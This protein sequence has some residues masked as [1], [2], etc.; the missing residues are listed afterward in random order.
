LGLSIIIPAFEEGYSLTR[1]ISAICKTCEN[2]EFEIIIVV[3]SEIDSSI[4]VVNELGSTSNSIQVLVQAGRGPLNAIKF[5]ISNSQHDYLVVVTADDTDDATDILKMNELFNSG[6]HYVCASRYI[7]GG[8]YS[9]GPKVKRLFSRTASA[10]LEIR[11]GAIASDPTNGYKGFS[12]EL[13]LAANIKGDVGFTYGL[14]LLEY[15]LR[16]DLSLAVI[17]TKWHDRVEGASSFKMLKWLPAYLYWFTM[18]F[19]TRRKRN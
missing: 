18:V 14:Q 13:F 8:D 1:T 16:N 15:A 9:G 3:D 10:L 6:A 7:N 17:P 5:G 11:H 4:G 12:R 19:F 2:L